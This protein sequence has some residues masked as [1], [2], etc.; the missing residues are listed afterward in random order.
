MH[1]PFVDLKAQYKSIQP[2]IDKAIADVIN[3]TAFIGGKYVAEFEKDLLSCT[4]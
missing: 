3:E 2:A 1:V 4:V